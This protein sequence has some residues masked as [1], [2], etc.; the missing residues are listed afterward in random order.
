M[1][2]ETI[3]TAPSSMRQNPAVISGSGGRHTSGISEGEIPEKQTIFDETTFVPKRPDRSF[4]KKATTNKVQK[5]SIWF[6]VVAAVSLVEAI[7]FG[8]SNLAL[9]VSSGLVALIF[10]ALGAL[11]F[12]VHKT[13]FLA[14]LLIYAGE[15][16]QL[17]V[18]G[19]KTSMIQ[20]AFGIVAHCAIAYRLYL[21]Y[22]M[23]CDLEAEDS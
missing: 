14:G 6:F 3:G 13:A 10:A 1:A 12:R 2:D 19:W 22:G 18:Q 9:A 11:A 23:I 5:A 8:A 17:L 4:S 21:A 16:M 20:V 7:F 15:T